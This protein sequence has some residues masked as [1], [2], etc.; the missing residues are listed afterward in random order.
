MYEFS[1]I[2]DRI[3]K[4][5]ARYR[6]DKPSIDIARYKLVTEFYM[7]H[8][9]LS[10]TLRRA[11]NFKNLCENLPLHVEDDDLLVGVY[12]TKYHASALYPENSIKWLI[13]ELKENIIQT[14]T[15][16]PYSITEE[17]KEYILSTADYW[18][19][20]SMSCKLNPYIPQ[21]YRDKASNGCYVAPPQ[22]QA[23]MP[24]GH[25][26]AN[27]DKAVR[28]GYGKTLEQARA[29]CHE[30]LEKGIEGEDAAKY[31]FYKSVEICCEGII[32][33]AKRY[34]VYCAELAQDCQD[35]NRKAELER[36]S[37]IMGWIMENGARDYWEAIEAVWFNQMCVVMDANLHG[38]SVGRLDQYVGDYL[39][40]DLA[41][42]KI[43][44]EFAQELMDSFYL[45]EGEINKAGHQHIGMAAPGYTSGQAITLGGTD[46]QG[47]D[48]TNEATY[49]GLESA[50]RLLLHDPPTALRCNP[51]MPAKLWD[52]AIECTKRAGG[53]P[54]FYSDPVQ[55]ATLRQS[56]HSEESANNYCV[57]GCV[58]PSG[59]GDD[60]A[61][62]GGN[63]T[64]AFMNT[65]NALLMG[66]NNGTNPMPLPDGSARP[67]TGP[68]TGY[69]YDMTSMDQVL[70]AV[71]T[72]VNYWVKWNV[73]MINIFEERAAEFLPQPFVSSLM[74]GC[75]ESG[76]DVMRG[77][78]TY[79]GCGLTAVGLGNIVDSLNIIDQVCFK[80]K[81]YTTRE[82]YDAI[83]A[84]WEGYDEMRGYIN[85]QVSRYG[86]GDPE[87][88]K[89]ASWFGD[90]WVNAVTSRRGPR[91]Y[92]KAGTWPVTMNVLY[93]FSTYATPDGRTAGSPLAD[94]ISAVQQ[95]DTEGPAAELRSVANLP[96]DKLE[97]GTLLNMKFHPTA[98]ASD[99][100]KQKLIDLMSTYFFA[101]GG[102]QMQINV[103]SADTMRDAQKHPENYQDLVV[104]IAGFSAYFV[105][106]YKQAQDDLIRRT[107]QAL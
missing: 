72:Q 24:V 103:V 9:E 33:F 2:T 51:K 55:I 99:S 53:V 60:W 26:C 27:N 82:L 54:S 11:Y 35:P 10:G 86:N 93:G 88:D 38:T 87:A 62:S 20:E 65:V 19:G 75:M 23:T 36:L 41:S 30:M 5:R 95:M 18:L 28:E 15:Y 58:E 69:L 57:I 77:G 73:T 14:R 22:D 13:P 84:N 98:L 85:N 90:V 37:D 91:G 39:E 45:K 34:S 89:Y 8:P 102:G 32:T 61:C 70:E 105:D 50:A 68:A 67:Q 80:T 106:V 66:I 46:R 79:N 94:G 59:C 81:K 48:A 49:M 31:E 6:T 78:A 3:A 16:D 104:R 12:V 40:R 101:M 47:N 100:G 1:P 74:E 44:R 83:M 76:K 107:E 7:N 92:Y 25:F 71:K 29:K 4:R 56:G 63:G 42:G 21:E 97:N 64:E 17:D 96:Q 52:C 43:T